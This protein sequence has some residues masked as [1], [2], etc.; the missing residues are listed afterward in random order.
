MEA[1]EASC[2]GRMKE[3]YDITKTLSNDKRKTTNAVKD[4]CGNLLTEGLARRK[5][6]KEHFEETLNRHIPD[7][8]SNDPM[9]KAEIRT[10]LRKIENGKAG[11]R[12]KLQQNY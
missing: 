1:E 12:T 4:K 11:A 7:E 6:W 5:R 9:T 3:V 8:I 10:A 2:N